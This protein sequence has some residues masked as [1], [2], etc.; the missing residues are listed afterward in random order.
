MPFEYPALAQEA[1]KKQET[2]KKDGLAKEEE[3]DYF[4]KWLNE[5]VVYIINSEEKAVF[6]NLTT[7]EEKEQFIEQFWRRRDPDLNTVQNEAKEEHYRRIAYANE[8]F[9]SGEPGWMTDRGR[10]YIVNGPPDEIEAHPAGG[11]YYRKNYEG[12]GSTSTFPF[13]VWW[14]RYMEG[15]GSD[16][17]LEFVDR[18]GGNQ[19]RLVMDPN[20]KDV[21]LHVQGGGQTM[22]EEMGIAKRQDRPAFSPYNRNFYPFMTLRAKD[23]P[24]VKYETMAGAQ[25]AKE[26]KYKDLQEIVKVNVQYNNLPFE[27]RQD[28]FRLN[29]RQVLVP[30]T[31]QLDN[32]D[33]TFANEPS[34]SVAKLGIYG[35]VTSLQNR[36][37]AE[38]EDEVTSRPTADSLALGLLGRSLYQKVLTLDS[39]LRYRLD[40]VVKDLQSGQIGAIRQAIIPPK[41][42]E[43]NLTASSLLLS[44]FIEFLDDPSQKNDG[45][46]V[47]GDVWVRPSLS[48]EFPQNQSLGLYLQL[49]NF[50]IDQA[51][52]APSLTAEYKVFRGNKPVLEMTDNSGAS[53]RFFSGQRIVLVRQLPVNLLDPGAYRVEVKV[54]DTIKNQDV[55]AT[56]QFVLVAPKG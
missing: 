40:L 27:L 29:E 4:Q 23:D 30:I 31:V 56:D 22:A 45:M 44:D 39:N 35:M 48:R 28:F 11:P 18:N 10:I 3:I 47:L 24:F 14:Y 41:F 54:H 20:Y 38:F 52:L 33:L 8:N 43:E 25:R 51:S 13:E 55:S 19:Y 50:G 15:V 53:V 16:I 32:K 9:A 42:Q 46:F 34:G 7:P 1:A 5:D 2:E 17:E 37:V 12:G 21:L 36:I 49:Y 6:N 26:V